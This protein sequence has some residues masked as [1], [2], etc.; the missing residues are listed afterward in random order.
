MA[1]ETY[2]FD[3]KLKYTNRVYDNGFTVKYTI[4]PDSITQNA[5]LPPKQ[6]QSPQTSYQQKPIQQIE[7]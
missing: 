7:K 4:D 1:D 3:R 5:Q 6:V 2:Y